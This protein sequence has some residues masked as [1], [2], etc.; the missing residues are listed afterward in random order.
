MKGSKRQTL[1]F[2]T[3]W[4]V[5]VLALTVFPLVAT[6]LLSLTSKTGSKA[7]EPNTWVGLENY[8]STLGVD[9]T[10]P[11]T[12]ADPWSW[13]RLDARP[14]DPRFWR[15]IENSA[16]FTMLFVPLELTAALALGLL[17]YPNGLRMRWLRAIVFAPYALGGIAAVMIWSWLLNPEF[18]AINGV[19]RRFVDDPP[20]WL[21]SSS[22]CKPAVAVMQLWSVGGGA[23]IFLAARRRIDRTLHEAAELD[24]AGSWRCLRFVTWPQLTPVVLFFVLTSILFS[25]Q[26]FNESFLLRNRR[27]G[28]GLLFFAVHLYQSAFEPPYR[29]A[30][31]C[32]LACIFVLILGGV[33][34]LLLL[35]S[36]AWVHYGDDHAAR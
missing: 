33:A 28:D 15:S 3:P 13:R 30:Y 9:S 8:R 22:W 12:A 2:L 19:L 6:V 31:A 10:R 1:A 25:M 36:R 16:V 35:S 18:G 7:G 23:M 21:F 26:A 5:G 14:L 32:T 11:A 29:L 34:G 24:G 17:L 4:L 20:D 27:Q